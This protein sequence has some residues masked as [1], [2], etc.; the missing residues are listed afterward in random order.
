M[1]MMPLS[2][3]CSAADSHK[4]KARKPVYTKIYKDRNLNKKARKMGRS[5]A[6]RNGFTKASP[7][8]V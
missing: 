2:I 4:G 7:P 3:V 8:T 5:G 6:W 1:M